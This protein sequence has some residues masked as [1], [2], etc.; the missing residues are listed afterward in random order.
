MLDVHGLDELAQVKEA[1]IIAA[2]IGNEREIGGGV[3]LHRAVELEIDGGAA[4]REGEGFQT[5]AERLDDGETLQARR[6]KK[7]SFVKLRIESHGSIGEWL[8]SHVGNAGFGRHAGTNRTGS[9]REKRNEGEGLIER[10]YETDLRGTGIGVGKHGSP[11]DG[12]DGD[13]LHRGGKRVGN[14]SGAEGERAGCGGG[15]GGGVVCGGLRVGEAE[16]IDDA[17]DAE[18]AIEISSAGSGRQATDEHG[19]G[20]AGIEAVRGGGGYGNHVGSS[21]GAGDGHASLRGE[22]LQIDDG[23]ITGTAGSDIGEVH[24]GLKRNSR[25][26]A[27]IQSDGGYRA[28]ACGGRRLPRQTN[29]SGLRGI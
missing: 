24:A 23:K 22:V 18:T 26:R 3:D 9:F 4:A 11:G 2:G 15:A 21:G 27:G 13:A 8:E 19:A 5:G 25:I 16:G 20:I 7:R 10:I 17:G 29:G 1:E 28:I 6:V 14:E 12:I